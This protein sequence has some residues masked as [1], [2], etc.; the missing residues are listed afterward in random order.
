[1]K[2][3]VKHLFFLAATLLLAS[4]F[5]NQPVRT[6]APLNGPETKACLSYGGV[7]VVFAG[8][9]GGEITKQE[10]EGQT[11]LQVK[12]CHEDVRIF[13]F[14][15]SITKS[16]KTTTLTTTSKVL[17]ADMRA[18][19]KSLTK[20]DAFEFRNTRAYLSNGK[21]VVDVRG[22]RFLVV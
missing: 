12:G 1:M 19:L 21:D 3:N 7:F 17:T 2:N 5:V 10:M 18:Q 6:G 22:S 14:T 16:G 8:K 9:Y 11:E 13:D 4:S 20:G 15:L